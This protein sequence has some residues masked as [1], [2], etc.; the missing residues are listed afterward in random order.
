MEQRGNDGF[1]TIV[2]DFCYYEIL[3]VDGNAVV[4]KV[5]KITNSFKWGSKQLHGSH[6]RQSENMQFAKTV[7]ALN[8]A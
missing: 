6:D 5:T 7:S 2:R 8:G 3:S 1:Q 4:G